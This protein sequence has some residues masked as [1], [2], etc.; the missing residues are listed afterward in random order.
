M[1]KRSH[2][3]C[4][5]ENV[6]SPFCVMIT[7]DRADGGGEINSLKSVEKCLIASKSAEH[8]YSAKH[9]SEHSSN[10]VQTAN[11]R[12][13]KGFVVIFVRNRNEIK[14]LILKL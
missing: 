3:G 1:R 7:G 12:E 14:T 9:K 4:L 13:E 5:D 2:R 6:F 8:V 11:K 10:V